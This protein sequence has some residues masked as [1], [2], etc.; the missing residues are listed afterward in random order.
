[1]IGFL[2]ALCVAG[3]LLMGCEQSAV[4]EEKDVIDAEAE[5][6]KQVMEEQDDVREAAEEGAANVAEERRE[7]DAAQYDE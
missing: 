2:S 5:A 4:E 1:M 3:S 6:A 7:A